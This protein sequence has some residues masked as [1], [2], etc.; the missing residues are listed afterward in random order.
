MAVE[1][2]DPKASELVVKIDGAFQCA[3]RL[4]EMR[5]VAARFMGDRWPVY[6][7]EMASRI[8]A[9]MEARGETNLLALAAELGSDMQRQGIRPFLFLAVVADMAGDPAK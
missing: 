8:R 6:R 2:Q 7:D 3:S 5:K 1:I 9:I 4:D